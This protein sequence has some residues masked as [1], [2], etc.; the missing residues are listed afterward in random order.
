MKQAGLVIVITVGAM[1]LPAVEAVAQSPITLAST[2]GGGI[3]SYGVVAT[4]GVVAQPS[5]PTIHGVLVEPPPVYGV[6]FQPRP[7]YGVE[8]APPT[9]HGVV[10]RPPISVQ[11]N[12]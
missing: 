9:F 2:L 11:G 8:V 12:Q 5:L 7:I 6:I 4:Y 1:A 3:P 10:V